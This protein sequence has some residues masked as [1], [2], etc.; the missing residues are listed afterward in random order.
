MNLKRVGYVLVC[1]VAMVSAT[2][3]GELGSLVEEVESEKQE[4]KQFLSDVFRQRMRTQLMARDTL[5]LS[6]NFENEKY[7][8]ELLENSKLFDKEMKKLLEKKEDTLLISK[9]VPDY[10]KR[11]S[12]LES[13]WKEF[14]KNIQIISKNVNDKKALTYISENNVL[15]L[16]DIDF[17]LRK[18]ME[19]NRSS[20]VLAKALQYKQIMLFSQIGMPRAY[21]QKIIKEKLLIEKEIKVIENRQN[22][23]I[24]IHALSRLLKAFRDGDKTLELEGTSNVEFLEKLTKVDALWSLLEPLYQKEILTEKEFKLMLKK[25]DEFIKLH[26]DLVIL[27][28]QIN[29]Q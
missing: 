29:D 24:T 15:L 28:N 8:K 4:K 12:R 7:K 27:S 25:S 2:T 18:Y 11:V 6:L 9:V 19:F 13:T 23:S 1:S 16:T 14:Y 20:D 26:T 22:L 10:Q 3:F 17:I 21:I 5:L